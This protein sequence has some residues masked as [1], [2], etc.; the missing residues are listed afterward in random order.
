MKHA[1]LLKHGRSISVNRG[2]AGIHYAWLAIT[3]IL[4]PDE[5]CRLYSDERRRLHSTKPVTLF[6]EHCVLTPFNAEFSVQYLLIELE[7]RLGAR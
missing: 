6:F 3:R 1:V 4:V 5:H 7:Q 2:T